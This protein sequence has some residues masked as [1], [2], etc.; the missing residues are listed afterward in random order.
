MLRIEYRGTTLTRQPTCLRPV[1]GAMLALASAAGAN[2]Q[3][4]PDPDAAF[5][6]ALRAGAPAAGA[7]QGQPAAAPAQAVR[8][9][10]AAIPLPPAG[11]I[12]PL[13]R[14]IPGSPAALDH[15]R[16]AIRRGEL[17][18]Y[19]FIEQVA[20]PLP[21]PPGSRA[22]RC[23]IWGMEAMYTLG[24]EAA[25]EVR[26]AMAGAAQEEASGTRR[27]PVTMRGGEILP[28]S[29]IMRA[30]LFQQHAGDRPENR[31]IL[32]DLTTHLQ[33]RGYHGRRTFLGDMTFVPAD[34]RPGR[35]ATR[36]TY[37]HSSFGMQ[38]V[39][40]KL[41]MAMP[42]GPYVTAELYFPEAAS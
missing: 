18:P 19:A 12:P 27:P 15:A 37:Y 38:D 34:A 10:R 7:E 16:D 35:V 2:A 25:E 39:C 29:D 14:S 8:S 20:G 13:F 3:H 1:L 32:A 42:T 36:L 40:G 24:H 30:I 23:R 6:A 21:L 33:A 11:T 5:E 22:M 28:A 4:A 41:G 17:D 26:R 9:R 31:R